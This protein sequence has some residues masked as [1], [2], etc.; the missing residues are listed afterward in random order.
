MR[1]SLPDWQWRIDRWSLRQSISNYFVR[2][3]V[4]ALPNLGLQLLD[5]KEEGKRV[6]DIMN[7]LTFGLSDT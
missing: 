7:T 3:P 4:I 2:F 5:Y 6:K 1:H